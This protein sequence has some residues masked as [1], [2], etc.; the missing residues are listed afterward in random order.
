MDGVAMTIYS[1]DTSAFITAWRFVYPIDFFPGLWDRIDSLIACGRVKCI[2]DVYEELRKGQDDL[3][4]WISKREQMVVYPVDTSVQR[5]LLEVQAQCPS[6]VHLDGSSSVDPLV[7]ALAHCL[8]GTT[9]TYE[10]KAGIGA[11]YIKIPNACEMLG[12]PC[13]DVLGVVRHERWT[14]HAQ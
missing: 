7:V 1:L 10:K 4:E 9:V 13:V 6:L 3:F 12:I 2:E 14:F 8:N 5:S 11:K